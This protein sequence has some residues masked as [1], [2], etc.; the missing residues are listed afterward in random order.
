MLILCALFSLIFTL[1]DLVQFYVKQF[2]CALAI[3]CVC[4]CVWVA[5]ARLCVCVGGRGRVRCS[6]RVSHGIVA[7]NE[8][9]L[10]TPGKRKKWWRGWQ[11]R[12]E[13]PKHRPCASAYSSITH[14]KWTTCDWNPVSEWEPNWRTCPTQLHEVAFFFRRYQPPRWLRNFQSLRS[15]KFIN[16][17]THLYHGH[18][19]FWA[20][21]IKSRHLE[22]KSWC[23]FY[24]FHT[25]YCYVSHIFSSLMNVL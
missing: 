5:L 1:L 18:L 16:V 9:I 19:L 3:L 2:I 22:S 24:N 14:S 17:F 25:I 11:V 6:E 20:R 12:T 8:P 15:P 23:L 21:W 7:S 13:I 10:P 4:A